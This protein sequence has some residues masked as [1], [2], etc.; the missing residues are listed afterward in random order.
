MSFFEKKDKKLLIFDL[1]GT[2]IDSSEGL[3]KAFKH[4]STITNLTPPS[5]KIFSSNIGPKIKDL[6]KFFYGDNL[7]EERFIKNF[8]HLYDE[9]YVYDFKKKYLINS[10]IKLL[11]E[12][13]TI[14]LTNKPCRP[15][16]KILKFLKLDSKI[17]KI[18]GI[19]FYDTNSGSKEKNI[20]QF[21]KRNKYDKIIYIGDTLEDLIISGKIKANFI[22][23]KSHFIWEK[24]FLN[25]IN[26][27]QKIDKNLVK[28]IE[29]I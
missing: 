17:R 21:L 15:S 6:F 10:M 16:S 13:E 22:G 11:K 20:L 7:A 27:F 5:K 12:F 24:I 26:I 29:K 28:Q 1:D 25:K 3:Y 18:I 8:R 2:L 19:D 4:A 14:I 9:I 23:I